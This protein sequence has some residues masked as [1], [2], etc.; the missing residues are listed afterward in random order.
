ML[1]Y[2]PLYITFICPAILTQ[3]RG[4]RDGNITVS[5]HARVKMIIGDGLIQSPFIKSNLEP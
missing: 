2:S 3:L 1:F 5:L 4:A